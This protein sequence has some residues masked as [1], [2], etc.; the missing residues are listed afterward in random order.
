[1]HRRQFAALFCGVVAAP[2]PALLRRLPPARASAHPV[3]QPES[4]SAQVPRL[5]AHLRS[6][7]ELK[8]DQLLAAIPARSGFTAVDCPNCDEGAQGAQLQWRIEDPSVVVCRYCGHRYPSRQYPDDRVLEIRDP[9]GRLQAYPYYEDSSGRKYFFQARGW[10]IARDYFMLAAYDLAQIF[11]FTRDAACA[12]RAA[13]ILDRFAEFYPGFLVTR[14]PSVWDKGFQHAPPYDTQGGKWG[15]WY[16]DELPTPLIRAYDLIYDS[17]E[18]E[19][20]GRERGVNVR[21]RIEDGFFQAAAAHVRAYPEP[22]ANPSPRIYEGLAV[23]GR[24]IGDPRAVHEA[25]RRLQGLF[26]TA[27]FFD[28]MWKEGTFGYHDM[29]MRGAQRAA[30][31]LAGYSDLPGYRDPTDGRRYDRLQP[32][33]EIPMFARAARATGKLRYPDGRYLPVH[34]SWGRLRGAYLKADPLE[35]SAPALWPAMGHAY[36]GRGRG[37]AQVQVHL[38]FGG[39]YG[40]AHNDSLNLA[41]FA[42]GEEL[43]P[44][45]GYTHTRYRSWTRS[46]LAHNTVAVDGEEQHTGSEA[47]P[48]DGNLLAFHAAGDRFQLVE[49]SGERA[50]PGRVETYRRALV[51]VGI[52]DD[53]AYV[54]D[55]FRVVGGRRHEWVLHGS[56]DRDQSLAVDSPLTRHGETLLPAGVRL[57]PPTSEE[58]SGAAEGHNP[59]YGFLRDVRSGAAPPVLAATFRSDDGS[60]ASLGVHALAPHDTQVFTGRA[61]S[62]R[63]AD[64]D[65]ARV[66]RVSMPW[67]LFRRE[68]ARVSSTFL[69]I[70]EPFS[71]EALIRQVRPLPVEGEGIALHVEGRDWTDL[72]LFRDIAE[73]RT[74]ARVPSHALRTDGRIAW[75]RQREG[76]AAEMCLIGGT[77]LSIGQDTLRSFGRVSGRVSRVLRKAAGDEV[78]ALE[79]LGSFPAQVDVAGRTAIVRYGD[80]STYGH[81]VAGLRRHNGRTLLLLDGEPGFELDAAGAAARFLFFPRREIRGPVTCAVEAL[82]STETRG[83]V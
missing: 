62:I 56:A 67:L 53:H 29:T 70:L 63:L 39:G 5:Q 19:R 7:I 47:Q 34:D 12:R 31:A 64:E 24:V 16:Y 55:V 21:A 35:S 11:H 72:I 60:G 22:Y 27:F 69:S 9:L 40:H 14:E 73:A 36:L 65:D 2:W 6:L 45:L 83:H 80:G 44:D 82:A 71:G 41:L 32:E 52:D 37:D 23:L 79:V 57:T 66:D 26:A 20:L 13:L 61:P 25:M 1:M 38:H 54:V 15:R 10:R 28:G 68:G 74:P 42:H 75:V 58:E 77:E 59:A 43:L 78:D 46:T 17:G 48:S 49:A 51:L 81:T 76:H 18:I 30:A 3:F 8:E 4:A 33:R 50:Y